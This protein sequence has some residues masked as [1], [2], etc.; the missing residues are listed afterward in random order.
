MSESKPK[1]KIVFKCKCGWVR[2]EGHS[3]L[4]CAKCGGTLKPI[5]VKDTQLYAYSDGYRDL[6]W[7]P[8][9]FGLDPRT[10]GSLHHVWKGRVG[11]I[12]GRDGEPCNAEWTGD[13]ENMKEG[14]M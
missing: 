9:R 11:K 8:C 5:P 13:K 12:C 6:H 7:K 2:P 14:C 3:C 10:C 1:F 4:K